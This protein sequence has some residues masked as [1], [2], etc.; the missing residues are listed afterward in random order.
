MLSSRASGRECQTGRKC[1]A[2]G[3]HHVLGAAQL[4]RQTYS[5]RPQLLEACTEAA[6]REERRYSRQSD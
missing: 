5:Y 3:Q 1:A 2:E 6:E 4:L